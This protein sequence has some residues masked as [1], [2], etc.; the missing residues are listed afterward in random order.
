MVTQDT[1]YAIDPEFATYGPIAFDVCKMPANLLLAFF[2]ADGHALAASEPRSLQQLW[3]LQV[4][5][6][7]YGHFLQIRNKTARHFLRVRMT[8]TG[9]SKD[10]AKFFNRKRFLK[11]FNE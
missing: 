2:A 7:Y 5:N 8:S 4:R 3:L 1:T 9:F 10:Q 6:Q 11:K